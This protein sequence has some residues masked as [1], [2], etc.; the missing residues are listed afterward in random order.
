MPRDASVERQGTAD[1]TVRQD[2]LALIP[3]RSGS[4]GILHKNISSVHGKPMLAHSVAHALAAKRVTR[5]VVSTDS[6][7]YAAIAREHGA[8][9]PFLRPAEAAGDLSTDLEVFAHALLW[10]E[11]NQGYRPDICVHLRPTYPARPEGVIDQAIALL[12]EPPEV[13]SVRSVAVAPF[14]PFK[15]WFMSENGLIEP[16][17]RC[18]PPEAWNLP[19]QALR[20]AYVQ[21]ACVDAVWSRVI[22]ESGSMTGA[23]VR[24]L[25]MQDALDVDTPAEMQSATAATTI[26]LAGARIA[27]DIDGVLA[28]LTP[29]NDYTRALPLVENIAVVNRLVAAGCEVVLFTARGSATGTDWRA[30]TAAQMKSWCVSYTELVFG[31]PAAEFYVDDRAVTLSQLDAALREMERGKR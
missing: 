15:M 23:R 5:V 27:V 22:R 29:D 3:A 6:E 1:H 30:L 2:V 20:T 21:N 19:R 16:C 24:A 7:L 12:C 25:V 17:V 26:S 9:V 28:S 14:T 18:G 31:K 11:E 13:D 8:D 4:K 10:L